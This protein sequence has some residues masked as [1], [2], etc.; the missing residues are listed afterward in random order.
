MCSCIQI[1]VATQSKVS[2]PC[3][4][5][6]AGPI[7]SRLAG[8]K[9]TTLALICTSSNQRNFAY[10]CAHIGFLDSETAIQ[11]SRS[12]GRNKDHWVQS[13]GYKRS[14]HENMTNNRA[15]EFGIRSRPN[16]KRRDIN[17]SQM[18][19]ARDATAKVAVAIGSLQCQLLSTTG[20]APSSW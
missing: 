17:S 10:E 16:T 11:E 18:I 8:A 2:C 6:F 1:K 20:S 4:S 5:A 15:N 7:S 19:A 3:K 9:R 13:F 14:P 12:E